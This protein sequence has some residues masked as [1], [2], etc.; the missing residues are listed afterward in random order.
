MATK[1]ILAHH[2]LLASL[3]EPYFSLYTLI[4]FIYESIHSLSPHVFPGELNQN[5]ATHYSTK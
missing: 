1:S 3:A 4:A 5:L 2:S